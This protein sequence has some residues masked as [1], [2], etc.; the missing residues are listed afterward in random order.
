MTIE[1]T[2]QLNQEYLESLKQK[3]PLSNIGFTYPKENSEEYGYFF[4]GVQK[5]FYER[6]RSARI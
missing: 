3:Y 5:A 4:I 1:Q 6:R 2:K